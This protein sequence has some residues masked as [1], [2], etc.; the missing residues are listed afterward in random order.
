RAALP[1]KLEQTLSLAHR[2]FVRDWTPEGLADP[3]AVLDDLAGGF[4]WTPEP[5]I[6]RLVLVPHLAGA[7]SLWL[8][9]HGNARV[10]GIPVDVADEIERLAAAYAAAG[11]EQ[12]LH[13]LRLLS[14]RQLGVSELARELGIAKS[15][16]HHHLGVLRQ[17]GLILLVG[18]AWRYSY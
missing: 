18:Q 1:P 12:R 3:F 16:A 7:P 8:L 2:T 17:A 5:G 15:T 6:T 11:D 9:Q 13:I 14:H 10:V 4:Q